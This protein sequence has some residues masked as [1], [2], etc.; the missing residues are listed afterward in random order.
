MNVLLIWK[1]F[2][3]PLPL[4]GVL[5]LLN[6]HTY[7]WYCAVDMLSS[8]FPC[9]LGLIALIA[10]LLREFNRSKDQVSVAFVCSFVALSFLLLFC[11]L[12]R[13]SPRRNSS[14]LL[15]TRGSHR[16][17]SFLIVIRQRWSPCSKA[18]VVLVVVAAAVAVVVVQ[19]VYKEMRSI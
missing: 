7:A 2:V 13:C 19:L 8:I 18:V 16:H 3:C 15:F 6:P 5:V 12:I 10:L 14:R 9:G 1:I 17:L 4:C 11:C